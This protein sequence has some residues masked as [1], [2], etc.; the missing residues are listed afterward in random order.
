V[1]PPVLSYNNY[2]VTVQLWNDLDAEVGFYEQLGFAVLYR[3]DEFPDFVAMHQGEVQFGIGLRAGF[4]PEEANRS[5]MWQFQVDDLAAVVDL[6]VR[7][8][9][10]H[11][12][13][14]LYWERMDAWEM[15][16]WSPNGYR[17]NLEGHAPGDPS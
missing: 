7:H 17:I 14:E 13:P 1:R 10:R 3:G 2:C 5:L 16:V 15:K 8:R 6:C 4:R 11:T 12:V 9:I